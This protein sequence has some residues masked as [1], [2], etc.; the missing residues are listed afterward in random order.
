[1]NTRHIT[2]LNQLA[3]HIYE[4]DSFLE[5]CKKFTGGSDY[6]ADDL[7]QEFVLDV[8]KM[9]QER[10]FGLCER[11]EFFYY[12]ATMIKNIVYRKSSQFSVQRRLGHTSDI[13][14]C[15]EPVSED[16]EAAYLNN[17]DTNELLDIIGNYLNNKTDDRYESDNLSW[18]SKKLFGLYYTDYK[19]YDEMSKDLNIPRSSIAATVLR[20]TPQIRE[21]FKSQYDKLCLDAASDSD[22]L[23]KEYIL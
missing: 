11:N 6:D 13:S 16:N 4:D 8:M 1:M 14:E 20:V 17:E 10:L 9:N 7:L 2:N 15:V 22:L 23:S 21:K 19:S 12:A 18:Y 3:N 5:Y